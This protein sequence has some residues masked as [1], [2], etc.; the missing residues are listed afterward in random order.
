VDYFFER[1][2]TQI[3]DIRA[4]AG[5][6]IA[7]IGD[8]TAYKLEQRGLQPDFVPPEFVADSLASHFPGSLQGASVLF[9]RVESG[10][11][12]V[13]VKDFSD[14]GAAVTEV[15]AYQSR[16]PEAIAPEALTALQTRTVDVITFASAKTVKALLSTVRTITGR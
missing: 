11:R 9:P 2:A 8:K 3:R 1:L 10:G 6:K 14:R 15:A 5:L 4:L 12:D 7:V 13:L 16:C